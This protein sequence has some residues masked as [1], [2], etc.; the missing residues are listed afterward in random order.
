MLKTIKQRAIFAIT[1]LIV[2]FVGGSFLVSFAAG[3]TA[4]VTLVLYGIV[5]AIMIGIMNWIL[6]GKE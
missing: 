4:I 1:S 2:L 6:G 3:V 5:G